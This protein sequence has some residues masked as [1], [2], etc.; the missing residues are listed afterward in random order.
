MHNIPADWIPAVSCR[1]ISGVRVIFLD[2]Y[3]FLL[4]NTSGQENCRLQKHIPAYRGKKKIGVTAAGL[5]F[6]RNPGL[7][8]IGI[9][10]RGN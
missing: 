10:D 5:R 6:P 9:N 3:L 8:S 2:S 7:Y 1:L 4:Y